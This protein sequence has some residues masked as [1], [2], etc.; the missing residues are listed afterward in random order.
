MYSFIKQVSF[1]IALVGTLAVSSQFQGSE[2]APLKI[3]KGTESKITYVRTRT[4]N[5]SSFMLGKEFVV[6]RMSAIS[7]S[8][9]RAAFHSAAGELMYLIESLGSA[10][11][12]GE[13]REG[14]RSRLKGESKPTAASA[15]FDCVRGQ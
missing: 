8:S 5:G 11:D 1:C 6:A 2:P 14:L 12:T 15:T 4:A 7:M 10:S 3:G 9:D 13:L